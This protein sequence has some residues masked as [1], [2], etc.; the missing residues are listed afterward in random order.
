MVFHEF[1]AGSEGEQHHATKPSRKLVINPIVEVVK[2]YIETIACSSSSYEMS[3]QR[4]DLF[5]IRRFL[6][7]WGN[8]HIDSSH[9]PQDDGVSLYRSHYAQAVGGAMERHRRAIYLKAF[10]G[11]ARLI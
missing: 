11:L 10:Y 4:G 3:T 1:R 8:F 7:L 9:T 5:F 6:Y 2:G